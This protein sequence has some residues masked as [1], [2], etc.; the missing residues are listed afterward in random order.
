MIK[1]LAHERRKHIACSMWPTQESKKECIKE[2]CREQMPADNQKKW[3]ISV[4]QSS[5]AR[6]PI[7]K[8]R[9]WLF[10]SSKDLSAAATVSMSKEAKRSTVTSPCLSSSMRSFPV[11]ARLIFPILLA[12]LSPGKNK[13]LDAIFK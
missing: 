4:Y 8:P 5:T 13:Y 1:M 10:A 9:V 2:R 3:D 12:C 7:S 11:A 6:N